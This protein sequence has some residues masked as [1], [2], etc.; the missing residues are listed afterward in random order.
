MTIGPSVFEKVCR[1]ARKPYTCVEC[2]GVIEPGTEYMHIHGCWD[3]E[4]D[5]YRQ[6]V[7]CNT[8]MRDGAHQHTGLA[9]EGP[10][11]GGVWD[12]WE[13]ECDSKEQFEQLKAS[14][15]EENET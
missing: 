12:W 9:E 3:G 14:Y 5:H 6:C 4:W 15:F 11:F 13:G 2:G 7:P 8:A 1:K 10:C